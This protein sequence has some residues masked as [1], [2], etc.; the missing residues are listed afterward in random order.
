VLLAGSQFLT[1]DLWR[2]DWL[3]NTFVHAAA[4]TVLWLMAKYNV[5]ARWIPN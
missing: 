3:V 5:A 4:L 1:F 2:Q